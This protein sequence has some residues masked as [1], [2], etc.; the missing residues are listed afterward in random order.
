MMESSERRS[1][2]IVP[3]MGL[4]IP[5]MTWISQYGYTQ[6]AVLVVLA[7][8]AYDSDDYI[9]DYDEYLTEV[10]IHA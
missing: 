2:S 3:G 5:P 9:R 4:Y 8:A 1:S 7:S 10:N 6:D